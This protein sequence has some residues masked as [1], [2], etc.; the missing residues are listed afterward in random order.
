VYPSEVEGFGLPIVESLAHGRPVLCG[1]TGAIGELA[2][3]GGC[4]AVDVTDTAA[5]REGLRQLLTDGTLHARLAMEARRRPVRTWDAYGQDVASLLR[6]LPN[7]LNLPSRLTD[8]LYAGLKA[9]HWQMNHAERLAFLQVLD[10]LR[11]TCAIEIGTYRGGSLSAMARACGVVFSIDIDPGVARRFADYDNVRF[12][13]GASQELLPVLLREL[14][15]V[16][17]DPEFVLI[18]GSHQTADV[19]A[20]LV[21][22]LDVVPRRPVTILVHDS[23]HPPCRQAFSLVPWE[24][25]PYVAAVE[26]DFV[27]GSAHTALTRPPDELYGGLGLIRLD[28]IRR[29]GPVV[30]TAGAMRQ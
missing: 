26:L 1:R 2:R 8:A 28:P 17:L 12:L 13:T 5:L 15:R 16:G 23:A 22:L 25:S 20:D 4:L 18:D 24:R 27:P 29:S 30:I 10:T 14:A 7:A 21:P 11:P 6:P 19:V 3:E 9:E